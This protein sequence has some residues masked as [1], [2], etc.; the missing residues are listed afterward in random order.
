MAQ[1]LMANHRSNR[2]LAALEP[3][4]FAAFEPHLEL[5]TLTYRQVLYDTG[6][7]VTH[8]YFPHNAIVSLVNVMEDV[9]TGDVGVFGCEGVPG[10]LSAMASRQAFGRYIVQQPGT[11]SR[12]ACERMK[13]VQHAGSKVRSRS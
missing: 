12:I 13:D 1:V 11:A 2:L 7:P 9:A 3:E 6:D 4:D 8:A 5:I 10:L